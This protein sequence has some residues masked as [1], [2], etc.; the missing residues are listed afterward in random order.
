MEQLR[1]AIDLLAAADVVGLAQRDDLA[2]LWRELARL[3]AQFA[4]RLAEWMELVH[5]PSTVPKLEV[6]LHQAALP[7][8]A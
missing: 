7:G 8:G 1:A 4:R 6:A 5:G 2:Q 3:D